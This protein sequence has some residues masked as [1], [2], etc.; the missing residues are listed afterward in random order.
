MSEFTDF[1][2][3]NYKAD[4]INYEAIK[5]L[6]EVKEQNKVLTQQMDNQF[7]LYSKF[8]SRL[9]ISNLICILLLI[10][11]ILQILSQKGII[12]FL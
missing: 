8:K 1:Q 9:N 10:I 4:D 11:Q 5:H 3:N 6:K 12:S 2:N 7:K